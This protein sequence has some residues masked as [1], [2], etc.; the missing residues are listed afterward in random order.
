MSERDIQA[1]PVERV[2]QFLQGILSPA[3]LQQL[4]SILSEI[5][6]NAD[7]PPDPVAM[8][9]GGSTPGGPPAQDRRKLSRDGLPGRGPTDSG[10]ERPEF[11]STS[12][13]PLSLNRPQGFDRRRM[14]RDSP[15]AF[16][17]MPSTDGQGPAPYAKGYGGQ[18]DGFAG[19]TALEAQTLRA[20]LRQAG[21]PLGNQGTLP[22]LRRACHAYGV[23]VEM[24]FDAAPYRT[25]GDADAPL[26]ALAHISEIGY[27]GRVRA[28]PSRPRS[29]TMALDAGS[30]PLS[31]ASFFPEVAARW[32][33]NERSMF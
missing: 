16:N 22:Q 27:A 11:P 5:D 19:D 31:V 32:A 4:E 7:G 9:P 24:A 18:L 28:S 3:E 10:P 21:M 2:R 25:S 13:A 17:G 20:R 6:F 33:I 23:P 29:T 26:D 15:P 12:G 30:D 14:G 8:Q 1:S